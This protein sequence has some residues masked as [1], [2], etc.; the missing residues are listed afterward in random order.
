MKQ[1]RNFLIADLAFLC[2]LLLLFVCILFI[3]GTPDS[4]QKNTIILAAVL[5]TVIITYFSTLPIGLILNIVMIFSYA[6][7]VIVYAAYRGVTI[8]SDIYF[9]IIWSPCMTTA[10]YLF[11]G[12]T[13]QAEK[14]N[15]QMKE[16]LVRLS[17]VDPETELKNIRSFEREC[18]VYMNISRRYQMSLVVVVWQFR[19]QRELTQ[20]LGQNGLMQ[21]AKQISKELLESLRQEDA[22]YMLDNNPF[23]WGTMLFTDLESTHIV[24]DRVLKRLEKLDLTSA[25]GKHK[26]NLEMR[27]GAAR[28]SE[29]IDT[30]FQLLEEA[31]KKLEYD[32]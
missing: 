30:P 24:V 15:E 32:V 12:R 22:L 31:K 14:H 16:Q 18:G 23:T 28:F 13:K 8:S 17:G 25:S 5:T 29:R 1:N 4:F 10:V 21:L 6:T 26:I 20:M 2:M 19:Y 3:S 27:S 11:S 9:W 7:Y